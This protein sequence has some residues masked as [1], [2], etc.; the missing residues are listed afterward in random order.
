LFRPPAE[1]TGAVWIDAQMPYVQHSSRG[2][3][4]RTCTS[5]YLELSGLGCLPARSIGFADLRREGRR[6]S[7]AL[8]VV[9]GRVARWRR[10][11][12][13]ALGCG[14]EDDDGKWLGGSPVPF[15]IRVVSIPPIPQVRR[16]SV[17]KRTT[18]LNREC[19]PRDSL[20]TCH[21]PVL[22]E[23]LRTSYFVVEREKRVARGEPGRCRAELK[24][25]K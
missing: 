13:W 21:Q 24:L 6:P 12:R 11:R 18:D 5:R 2:G 16:Y 10:G 1:R 7:R 20:T 23:V 3:G 14:E 19:C 9:C 25:Y 17:R 22:R 15:M 8:G 4:G